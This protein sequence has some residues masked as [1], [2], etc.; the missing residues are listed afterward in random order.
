MSGIK[1]IGESKQY[2]GSKLRIGIVHARWNTKIIDALLEGA[3]KKLA[4][5]GVPDSNIEIQTVPGSY[6]LPYAVQ[7]MY[8]CS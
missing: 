3:K 4:E 2:D 8:A 6:E 5:A 1:G 7:Q